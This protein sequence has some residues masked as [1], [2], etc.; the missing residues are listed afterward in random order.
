MGSCLMACV[1]NV[2]GRPFPPRT[3]QPRQ[4]RLSDFFQSQRP[5]RASA[6]TYSPVILTGHSTPHRPAN[7]VR[8]PAASVGRARH[9]RTRH[10]NKSAH[11]MPGGAIREKNCNLLP[12][13]G[14]KNTPKAGIPRKVGNSSHPPF[15]DRVK[16][17]NIGPP[18]LRP[19]FTRI[20]NGTPRLCDPGKTEHDSINLVPPAVCRP[21]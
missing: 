17:P 1:K 19:V 9:G 2:R 21:V 6:P 8:V 14:L 15:S 13:K 3:G 11:A 10:W 12:Y 16:L 18:A 20:V 5:F 4:R 7:T